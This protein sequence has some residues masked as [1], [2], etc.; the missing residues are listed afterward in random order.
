M[1]TD[2]EQQRRAAKAMGVATSVF[3]IFFVIIWCV[4]V[5]SMGAWFML[6]FA[7]PIAVFSVCRL[8]FILRQEKKKDPW[9]IPD[10]RYPD[11]SSMHE[12]AEDVFRRASDGK[13]TGSSPRFCHSCSH[14]IHN[15]FQFCPKCGR[16]I[17]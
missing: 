13:A 14:W 7:I 4:I 1:R 11:F 10:R 3:S 17:F 9:D 5:A 6:L 12:A 16:R 2:R 15:D 8:V